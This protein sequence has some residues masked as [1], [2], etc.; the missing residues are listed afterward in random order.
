[1][2]P[3]CFD[4]KELS[5]YLINLVGVESFSGKAV[6]IWSLGVTMYCMIYNQLPF[7]HETDVGLFDKILK[8]E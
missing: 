5:L 1:M 8:D 7:W 3:E 2:A 4:C 6:D